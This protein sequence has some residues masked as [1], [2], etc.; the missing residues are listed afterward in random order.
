MRGNLKADLS[1]IKSPD[2]TLISALWNWAEH[3]AKMLTQIIPKCENNT[4]K[5][6]VKSQ[7]GKTQNSPTHHWLQ[8]TTF[9]AAATHIPSGPL[10]TLEVDHLELFFFLK[11]RT[12]PDCSSPSL[13]SAHATTQAGLPLPVPKTPQRWQSLKFLTTWE[14]VQP[15]VYN[16][17]ELNSAINNNSYEQEMIFPYRQAPD[18]NTACQH[19][20][21]SLVRPRLDFWT[22]QL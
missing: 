7:Q 15:Q 14:A 21:F 2:D 22:I 18:R 11:Q 19:P 10:T 12:D 17:K 1:L 3:P 8:I 9:L 13:L 6:T 4:S 16:H 5:K 20:D